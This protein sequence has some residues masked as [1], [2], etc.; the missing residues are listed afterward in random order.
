MSVMV[1]P[2]RSGNRVSGPSQLARSF[3][4]ATGFFREIG[5]V[6]LAAYIYFFVRGLIEARE[7]QA[8]DNA[9]WL[10]SKERAL[11]IFQEGRLQELILDHHWLVT[12]ANWVYIYGHW[13][14]VVLT[15]GWLFV[16]HRAMFPVFRSAMLLSGAMGIVF[17]VL[18]PM[19]PPRFLGDLGF[20]DTVTMHSE[21][22]RVLQPPSMTNQFAAMPS[23]HVGWNLLMGIAI[24]S[25]ASNRFWKIFGVLMPIAMYLATIVTANHYFLDG[26]VGSALALTGLGLAW[27]ISRP[28]EPVWTERR[29]VPRRTPGRPLTT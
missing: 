24:V 17:F 2:E 29:I 13:P 3:P 25:L 16:K 26:V 19:A 27:K 20:V 15:L 4:A 14:V 12:L 5:I 10:V 7:S 11:G 6:A 23:L 22:Y 18:F 8:F 21:A 9:R 1:T 28:K